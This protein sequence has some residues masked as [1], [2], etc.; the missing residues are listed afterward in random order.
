MTGTVA[1]GE[2]ADAVIGDPARARL[3]VPAGGDGTL[4]VLEDRAGGVVRLAAITTEKAA[5]T[6]AVDPRTGI[7]YL[8]TAKLTP[9]KP[10]SRGTPVAGSF[11]ILAVAPVAP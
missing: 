8:P 1:I 3:Y 5:R 10:G 4:T 6:G 9:G 7:V 11:H 2:G